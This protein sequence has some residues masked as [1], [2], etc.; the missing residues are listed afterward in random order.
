[1]S[2]QQGV[3]AAHAVVELVT[4][5][6]TRDNEM[7]LEWSRGHK[8]LIFLNAGIVSDLR[9]IIEQFSDKRNPY[10]WATFTESQDFLAG[11][12]TSVAIVLPERIFKLGPTLNTGKLSTSYDKIMGVHR[13]LLSGKEPGDVYVEEY[14]EWEWGLIERLAA[15]SL[16]R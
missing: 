1:M 6:K 10:P 11:I 2:L 8:T 4:D 14:S 13:V 5:P 3:Q 16:A 12:T 9:A 15:S 7:V